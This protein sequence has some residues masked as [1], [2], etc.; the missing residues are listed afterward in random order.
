MRILS[1]IGTAIVAAAVLFSG[2]F[3]ADAVQAMLA[4]YARHF[5]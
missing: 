5:M 2:L 1:I 4:A 3:I